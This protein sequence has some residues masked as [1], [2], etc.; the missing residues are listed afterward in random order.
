MLLQ[1][2]TF[3][4]KL[5][6]QRKKNETAAL[7]FLHKSDKSTNLHP[8]P[9]PAARLPD[10]PA[11]PGEGA[12]R[13]GSRKKKPPRIVPQ[14]PRQRALPFRK[15]LTCCRFNAMLAKEK[16]H[17]C[18]AAHRVLHSRF[19]FFHAQPFGFVSS[20]SVRGAFSFLK[21]VKV[22]SAH[23]LISPSGASSNQAL[24]IA[25]IHSNFFP[26]YCFR[27]KAAPRGILSRY[28]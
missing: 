13:S 2:Y 26:S 5:S 28:L 20:S 25:L 7:T 12:A 9:L 4:W 3:F 19:Y 18:A 1:C 6:V 24:I 8:C 15:E 22:S 10:H 27:E 23:P 17:P 14:R 16:R 21:V 11:Y